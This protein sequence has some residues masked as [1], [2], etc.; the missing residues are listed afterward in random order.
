MQEQLATGT[1]AARRARRQLLVRGG[2]VAALLVAL[3]AVLVILDKQQPASEEEPAVVARTVTPPAP[4]PE[5]S[6]PSLA[7]SAQALVAQSADAPTVESS[8]LSSAPLAAASAPQGV[9]EETMD[10]TAPVLGVPQPKVPDTASPRPPATKPAV[11]L[12]PRLTLGQEAPKPMVRPEAAKPAAPI[13]D[14]FVVQMGVFSDYANA[15][16]LHKRLVA[17]GVTARLETRVQVGPF[18]NRQE[19]LAAQAQLK[20]LGLDSGMVVAAHPAAR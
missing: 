20:K 12:A 15:E 10:P 4:R 14:G 13:R 7:D 1:E 6:A 8:S 9:P 5:V 16:Q 19:A 2:T 18:K 17:A 11:P 3:L